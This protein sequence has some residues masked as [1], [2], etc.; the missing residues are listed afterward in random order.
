LIDSSSYLFFFIATAT[1]N[2]VAT[3]L[4]NNEDDEANRIVSEAL[5]LALCCGACLCSLVLFSG[6]PLL[7]MI[8]GEAS[9]SVVPSALKYALVRAFGQP[10]VIMASVA[11]AAGTHRK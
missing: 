9:A 4:A 2:L 5:F 11:R 3:A 1:T 10:F 6:Q 8:A 7:A